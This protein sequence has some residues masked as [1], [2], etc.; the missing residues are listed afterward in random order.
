[1]EGVRFPAHSG[2]GSDGDEENCFDPQQIKIKNIINACSGEEQVI[3][4]TQG[5]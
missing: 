5:G 3:S 2:H 1:M 4:Y